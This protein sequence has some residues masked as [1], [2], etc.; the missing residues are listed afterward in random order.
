MNGKKSVSLV[1]HFRKQRS[2]II[3]WRLSCVNTL[4]LG[5]ILNF[6][7]LSIQEHFAITLP[8]AE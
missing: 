2:C 5:N 1:R 4:K 3:L 8:K 7:S 6:E